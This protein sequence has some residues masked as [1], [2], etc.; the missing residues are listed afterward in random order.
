[1]SVFLIGHHKSIFEK[2]YKNEGESDELDEALQEKNREEF[3]TIFTFDNFK[4][5]YDQAAEQRETHAHMI[6]QASLL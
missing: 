5:M 1:M 2:T 6:R 4:M 3:K